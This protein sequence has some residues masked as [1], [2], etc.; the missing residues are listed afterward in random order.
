MVFLNN[1]EM[2]NKLANLQA[3]LNISSYEYD[4]GGYRCGCGGGATNCNGNF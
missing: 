3:S 4:E 2:A 1:P